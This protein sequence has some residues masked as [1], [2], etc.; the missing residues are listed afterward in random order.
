MSSR[1]FSSPFSTM[2]VSRAFLV[3]GHAQHGFSFFS[4]VCDSSLD[5]LVSALRGEK[6]P[7]RE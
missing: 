1:Q 6:H 5:L 2:Q 7:V 4:S 3:S